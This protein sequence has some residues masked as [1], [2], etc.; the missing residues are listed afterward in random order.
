MTSLR[1]VVSTTLSVVTAAMVLVLAM[2]DRFVMAA[3]TSN[4]TDIVNVVNE[5]HLVG[6]KDTGIP[7]AAF[8]K[9][10]KHWSLAPWRIAETINW[11]RF[12]RQGGRTL[13]F[14]LGTWKYVQS[15]SL[16]FYQKPSS[17][18]FWPDTMEVQV[19]QDGQNWSL[20]G[21]E[22][23]TK[24]S[25]GSTE[26]LTVSTSRPVMSAYMRIIFPV[27][28]WV[29]ANQLKIMNNPE[30]VPDTWTP[31]FVNNS[32]SSQSYRGVLTPG[33]INRV[34]HMLLAYT[35]QQVTDGI[36][37]ANDFTP[38]LAYYD[39]QS[40][41]ESRLFDTILF[42]PYG[43]INPTVAGWK[44]Y[45]SDLFGP[46]GELDQLNTAAQRVSKDIHQNIVE[47]VVISI[48]YPSL[49]TTNFGALSPSG[50]SLDFSTSDVGAG[51]SMLNRES[52]I[53]WFY[54]QIK[55]HWNPNEYQ[56]LSLSGVY[57]DEEAFD[58]GSL[59]DQLVGHLHTLTQND[60]LSLLWIPYFG[61]PGISQ[62]SSLGFDGA[63]LQP[64]Y[65]QTPDATP[66]RVQ[67]AIN[68]ANKYG[69]GLELELGDQALQD[70]NYVKRYLTELQVANDHLPTQSNPVI[71][72]YAGSKIL[73]TAA[74]STIPAVRELY[75]TTGKFFQSH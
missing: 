31:P 11:V 1:M 29:Y 53:S 39:Q 75:D 58:P 71:A 13:S 61:A 30:S 68:I 35:G 32:D 26:T 14:N 21:D 9:A 64:N 3:D 60:N 40:V 37:S 49:D 66:Y 46:G 28:I 6:V 4:L 57:W 65:F 54:N 48:P 43:T 38:M 15:V 52:A 18:V 23:V 2:A 17:G 73:V 7:D 24:T 74:Q 20:L 70:P 47:N 45:L 42:L 50:H 55:S 36:W 10:E 12:C 34:H 56:N 27:A 33:A 19:S 59:D 72:F 8:T 25:S 16:D 22:T 62:W 63:M 67:E 41:A 5:A 69:L 44:S 51:M